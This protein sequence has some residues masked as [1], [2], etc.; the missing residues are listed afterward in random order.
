MILMIITPQKVQTVRIVLT[1]SASFDAI[2]AMEINESISVVLEKP[3]QLF[4][5]LSYFIS[6]MTRNFLM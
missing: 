2:F 6:K 5:H 3:T 1:M 4:T